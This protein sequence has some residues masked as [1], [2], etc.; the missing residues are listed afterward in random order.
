[1]ACPRCGADTPEGAR[2]CPN[3]GL[4]LSVAGPREE[5]K[6]VSILFV[7]MVGSTEQADGADPEDVRERNQLYYDEV[8][9]RIEMHG[10]TVEKYI[11][12]AVLAVFGAPLASAD[13][14]ERAVRASRSV[15]EGI[16]ELNGRHPGLDIAVRAA[17]GTGE[18]MVTID[19]TPEDTLATGDI[20]NTASRLQNAAPTGGVIVD[21]ET[22]RLTRHAFAYEEL[23]PVVAKGKR[24]PVPAWLVGE[25]VAGARPISH[26]PLVGRDQ[27]LS[28]IRSAW[29][30][31]VRSSRPHLVTVLGPAGIGKTRLAREVAEDVVADGRAL[32]GR[33]L[34]YEE[35]TPYL[36]AGEIVRRAAGI[37]ENEPAD[38]ARAKLAS[39]A[40]SLLPATDVDDATRYLSLLLGLGLDEP[41]DDPIYLQFAARQLVERLAER[42]PLLLVFEDLHW[43][44]DA[45]LELINYLVA[46]VRNHRV[47]FL[48]LA[49]PEFL[50][51]RPS[52]GS[53]MTGHTTLPL[54]PLLPDEATE[55]VAALLNDVPADALERVVN[56]AGGNPLFIEELAASISDDPSAEELPSTVRAA[57]AARIDSLPP[58]SRDVILHASVIGNTFWSGVVR[59]IGA[60]GDVEEALDALEARG[61]VLR[62]SES[63]IADDVEY[64]FKHSLIRDTA[65]GTLPRSTRRELH[66]AAARFIEASVG[67]STELAWLLGHH[68]REAGESE[69]AM[70]SYVTAAERTRDALA[71]EETY[72]LYSR[73]LELA[74][75]QENRVRIRFERALSLTKLEDFARAERELA[76]VIPSLSGDDEI[77]ALIA[78]ARSSLWTEQTNQTMALAMRAV[79]LVEERAAKELE[80]PAL[81]LLSA[82]YTMRG[83]DGDLDRALEIG[84]RALDGWV[85]GTRQL[86]LAE[87]YH[88]HADTNYWAGGYERTLELA[89]LSAETGRKDSYSAEYRLRG[90]GMQGLSLAGV[91]RYEESLV[92]SEDAIALSRKLGRSDSVVMNYSTLA[93]REIFAVDEALARSELVVSRLGPSSFNM[94]WLNGRADLLGSLL[95]QAELG[96]VERD[97]P[98]TWDDA[99]ASDAWEHW[100]IMGRLA[101]YRADLE[102]QVGRLDE[103]VTWARRALESARASRRPKYEAITLTTLGKAVTRQGSDASAEL[104]SAVEIADGLGSPLLRWQTRAALA[105][106]PGADRDVLLQEAAALIREVASSLAPERS[107]GYQSAPQVVEVLEAAG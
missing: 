37:F 43:A 62:R 53:G 3:C 49:R 16:D 29:Q 27:E 8:R 93:L 4:D 25:P 97:W 89:R 100:L 11:G 68:W 73:A 54:E 64:A 80:G 44:D 26:T 86:E 19:A 102:L 76:E 9:G 65:Y 63:S 5:R 13:D 1:M 23:P 57:I 90:V 67:S 17:V 40:A 15:L 61:L 88:L 66:A 55:V 20:V 78:R 48:A 105:D 24:E 56:T 74:V 34:P 10:G 45:L 92:A 21:A 58:E 75:S 33:S 101:A 46:H 82:A 91:G 47:V 98:G 72:D 107:A 77:E 79:E 71:V 22:R 38:A 81:A 95:L 2:F 35:P 36:A 50:E 104:R 94:P 51:A 12:D 41:T 28:L 14:A 39:L 18:A 59:G 52:W 83:G 103:A 30:R 99:V 6:F 106:A 42:E 32:W 7:D 31:A 84:D 96:R 69:R 70:R 87:H 60:S 85:P